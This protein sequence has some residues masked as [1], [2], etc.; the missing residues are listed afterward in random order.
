M[1]TGF[2]DFNVTL[3]ELIIAKGYHKVLEDGQLRGQIL[4]LWVTHHL[5]EKKSNTPEL[6]LLALLMGRPLNHGYITT[7]RHLFRS[8]RLYNH[9]H[10]E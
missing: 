5:Q 2:P 4:V 7:R 8:T 1:R 3:D 10:P 6:K 9:S